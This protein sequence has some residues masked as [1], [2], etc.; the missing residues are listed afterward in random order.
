MTLAREPRLPDPDGWYAQLMAA[1]R[2]L[3]EAASRQ[4][5]AA[6]VVLLANHI[7]DAAGIKAMIHAD[8]FMDIV[9]SGDKPAIRPSAARHGLAAA[10]GEGAF[11][12]AQ[13]NLHLTGQPRGAPMGV[14]VAAGL[15]AV[16]HGRSLAAKNGG[17]SHYGMA[18]VRR[19]MTWRD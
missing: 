11:Q 1:H 16:R 19:L 12:P 9:G 15:G 7:G 5:D 17:R 18:W 6:L 2:D 10:A 13:R 3:D 14:A 4:L 8:A